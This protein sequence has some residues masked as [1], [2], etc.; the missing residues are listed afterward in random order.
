[1]GLAVGR[2]RE[3]RGHRL[4][5]LFVPPVRFGRHTRYIRMRHDPLLEPVAPGC[6]LSARGGKRETAVTGAAERL[7]PGLALPAEPECPGARAARLHDQI[8]TG[9]A[10]VGIFGARRLRPKR[11]TEA[12]GDGIPH[13]C[14]PSR[15]CRH[16]SHG[17]QP[18]DRPR[19]D[20]RGPAIP[21][22]TSPSLD[23]LWFWYGCS[24]RSSLFETARGALSSLVLVERGTKQTETYTRVWA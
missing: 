9:A 11:A 22:G 17:A 2:E 19:R 5:V 21:R 23:R 4:L 3:E 24:R 14:I 1:G 7:F 13:D 15:G 18:G 20:R 16:P 12:M 10:G 6:G 8:E